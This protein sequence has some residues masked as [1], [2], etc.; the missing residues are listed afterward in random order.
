MNKGKHHSEEAKQH[1]REAF[2]RRTIE[3]ETYRKQRIHDCFY[4]KKRDP[5]LMKSIGLKHKKPIVQ[6]SLNGKFIQAFDSATD[7]H[8]YNNN[9]SVTNITAC[10]KRRLKTSY[11]FIFKYKEDCVCL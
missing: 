3:S 9:W 10:C 6:L 4:G 1:M 7:A 11:G 5:E 8:N 2:F